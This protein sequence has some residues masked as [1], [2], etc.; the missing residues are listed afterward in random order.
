MDARRKSMMPAAADPYGN[1]RS[2]IP[3]PA[4]IKKPTPASSSHLRMS[5]AGPALRAPYPAPPSTNPR[6]SMMR[7]QNVNPILQSTSKPNYGRTP[8]SK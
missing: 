6:Q 3:V 1:I 7:S 8:L 2:G 4:T 5:L